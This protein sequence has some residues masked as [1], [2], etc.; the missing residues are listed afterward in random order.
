MARPSPR[1][2]KAVKSLLDLE[3]NERKYRC[4]TKTYDSKIGAVT[5]PENHED[6]PTKATSEAEETTHEEIQ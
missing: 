3:Y 5:V 4:K 2:K 6:E 1:H